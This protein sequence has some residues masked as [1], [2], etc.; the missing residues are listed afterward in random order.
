[1]SNQQME[2][3]GLDRLSWLFSRAFDWNVI[4]RRLN[5]VYDAAQEPPPR[6]KLALYTRQEVMITHILFSLMIPGGKNTLMADAL[7]AILA[8]IMSNQLKR[9][10]HQGSS[11]NMQR[12]AL[13]ILLYQ[14]EH[15]KMPDENWA[16]QIEKYLGDNPEQYFSAPY[17]PSPKGMTIYAMVQYGGELPTSPDTLLL[18]ELSEAV[19][20]NRA[21]ITV[22]E[23][24]ERTRLDEMNVAYR[25]GTVRGFCGCTTRK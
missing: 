25:S 21:V 9:M 16:T 1:L 18:V 10:K 24:L 5:D 14:L 7:T 6:A 11:E 15:G 20:V 2:N 12:L 4:F 19:P 3:F 23:V 17:N 13:A 8:P 22:D